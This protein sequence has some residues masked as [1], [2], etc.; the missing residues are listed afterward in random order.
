MKNQKPVSGTL[1][2][3]SMWPTVLPPV[4]SSGLW[5][6]VRWARSRERTAQ[7]DTTALG[8]RR[9]RAQNWLVNVLIRYLSNHSPEKLPGW[10]LQRSLMIPWRCSTERGSSQTKDRVCQ[11]V[12]FHS[13]V[14]RKNNVRGSECEKPKLDWCHSKSDTDWG[15]GAQAQENQSYNCPFLPF[16]LGGIIRTSMW[17]NND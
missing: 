15:G 17:S 11:G 7:V 2:L 4:G 5:W 10:W 3:G 16:V 9:G 12:W 13:N 8:E 6:T 1:T 14:E